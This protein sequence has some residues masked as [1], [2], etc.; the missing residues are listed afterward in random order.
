MGMK[1]LNFRNIE[2]QRQFAM[3]A[4]YASFKSGNLITAAG[5]AMNSARSMPPGARLRVFVDDTDETAE[6]QDIERRRLDLRREELK[7]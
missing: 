2:D 4:G 7:G 6:A 5:L 1:E 3:Q